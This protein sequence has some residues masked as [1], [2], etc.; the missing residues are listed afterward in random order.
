LPVCLKAI[1]G[2]VLW[3]VKVETERPSVGAQFTGNY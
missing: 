2:V 3:F 1:T